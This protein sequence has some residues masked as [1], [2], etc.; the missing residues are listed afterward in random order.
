MPLIYIDNPKGEY[1]AVEPTVLPNN[2]AQIARNVRLTSGRID[3]LRQSLLNWTP[4]KAGLIK[5]IYHFAADT[6]TPY[7]FHWLDEI[8]VVRSPIDGDVSERTYF[9]GVGVPPQVT[10]NSIAVQGGNLYPMNAYILGIPVPTVAPTALATPNVDQ[11][12]N[13][14]TTYVY[15]YVSA[16]GEEGVPSPASALVD[17]NTEALSVALSGMSGAPVGNYNIV[18]KRIYR[19]ASS[20]SGA[21]FQFVAEI[22]IGDAVYTDTTATDALA[23]VLVSNDYD[24]PP[25][26]MRG[27]VSMPNGIIAGF[28][29]NKLLFSEP[30]QPHAYPIIYRL[31]TDYP[32]VALAAFG[33]SLAVLTTNAPY[34]VS[35]VHPSGMS[36]QKIELNQS[37]SSKRGVVDMGEFIIYPSPD[38]L[39]SVGSGS[40]GVIT[41]KL[42][43]R[44][45]WQALKPSSMHAYSIDGMYICFYDT[46]TTQAGF[47]L[48]PFNPGVGIVHIDQYATAGFTD[49]INDAL[50]LV[51]SVSGDIV[52]WN[53]IGQP[54]LSG[55]WKSKKYIGSP[56]NYAAMKINALN[57]P[58]TAKV[59]ADGVLKHTQQ[60]LNSGVFRLPSGFMAETW[61]I[62]LTGVNAIQSIQMATSVAEL[63]R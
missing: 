9:A 4:T 24:M 18:S 62:E 40:V 26:T 27:M 44:D 13:E 1:P 19:A 20:L 15:T 59:F 21:D 50:Y 7:W 17:M 30:F 57:Y 63:K 33:T 6:A 39:V 23:E 42:F 51:D 16:M 3:P 11:A 34:I 43:T 38:G 55:T 49:S 29:G 31:S 22:P 8:D 10:D 28:D 54:N 47:I 60:V 37:C 48:D 58:V 61:E 12:L 41:R 56:T 53:A 2:N 45:E 32:I 35:G 46:G 5:T 52:E 14:T 36:M 25:A